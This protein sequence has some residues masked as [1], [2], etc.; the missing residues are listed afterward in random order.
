MKKRFR[1]NGFKGDVR[2]VPQGEPMFLF[3]KAK[4]KVNGVNVFFDKGC[5]T[6]VF[7]EGIPGKE[8]RGLVIKKG[9]FIMNIVGGIKTKANNMWLTS[10]DLADGGKQLVQGLSVDTVTMEFPLISLEA[11][12]KEVKADNFT[13]MQSF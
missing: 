5:S 13:I 3:F 10:L 4:G 7:K 12:V 8:L 9:P 1:S 11:A 2:P 6:A